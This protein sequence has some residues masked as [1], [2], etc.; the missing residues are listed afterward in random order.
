MGKSGQGTVSFYLNCVGPVYFC[1]GSLGTTLAAAVQTT[2]TS[3]TVT[4]QAN[5]DLTALPTHIIL[6]NGSQS[7][8]IRICG[9]TANVLSV[10]YDGRGQTPLAFASGVSVL[11]S[12]VTGTGTKFLTDPTAPVCPVGAPGP[13]GPSLY[14]AGTVALTANSATVTGT[15]TTFTSLMVGDYIRVPATHAGTAFI[16]VAQIAAF[17]S[18]TSLTLNRVYPTSADTA[19]GLAYNIMTG[20][21]TIVLRYPHQTDPSG[22][23]ELMWGT[24][25]GCESET[26]VYTNPIVQGNSFASGHDLGST[27]GILSAGNVYSVTDTTGWVNESSTGGINF[28]GEGMAHRALYYRSGLNSALAAA[29]VIDNYWIRSPW[30]N[31]DGNGYPRLFLGGGGIGAFISKIVDPASTV[32]WS[33]LR[34]Y[35]GLG[36][37]MINGF[38]AN[39]CNAWDDTRDSG[40]AYSWLIIAAIY[41]PDTTSTSAPGGIPWRTYWQNQLA[42]MKTNDTNCQNQTST[43]NNSFANGFYWNGNLPVLTLTNGSA[44]AT[45][46]GLPSS[47]CNGIGSGTGAVVN[48]SNV[49]TAV[50]GTFPTGTDLFLTGT[51]GDGSSVFVQS[52][53]Y[54]GTGAAG[55]LGGFWM[56]DSGTV[57]WIAG[58]FDG[59]PGDGEPQDML[60]IAMNNNDVINLQKSWACTWNSSTSITLNRPWDGASSDGTHIYHPYNGNLAGFGQQAFML[61]IKSYG[62]NLLATQT[63]PALSSYVAPYQ[64]FTANSTSWVWNI[65]MDH[66]LLGTNYGRIFQQCEPGNTAPNG[67]SSTFRAAGCTYGNDPTAVYLSR[68]QNSET[69]AA[70]AIYYQ[71]NPTSAS[72]SLGDQ[73]YGALWG[74]CPWTTGGVYCDLNSTAAN[75]AGSNLA[76]QSVHGGKWFGFFAGIGM[77]HRWPAVRQG[78]VQPRRPRAVVL[79]ARLADIPAAASVSVLVTAPSGAQTT[80]PCVGATCTVTVDDRQGTH[81]YQIQYLSSTGRVLSRS[82]PDLILYQ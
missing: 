69:G 36:L 66:Q 65:G 52:L 23:G 13:P 64:S 27:N 79:S 77:S 51:T 31:A 50:T 16:F 76:D 18:A 75:A 9:G 74:Y 3:I 43:S 60:A 33:D 81:W 34:G 37:Q 70:H 42:Q 40:Y 49:I 73:F 1:N 82:Q 30:G 7:E 41:D 61:G 78:S 11:Q 14:S 10:C 44:N 46:T 48:G 2:D 39:G 28:Y 20:S 21:R 63:L 54:S 25:G 47:M 56:G 26:S 59:Y 80:V 24:S 57:S 71:N 38:T 29:Q 53:S 35:A 12:K 32:A 22:L 15:G 67:T 55:T 19:A 5:L 6:F 17:N 62:E 68:E 4:N 45:G 58:N 72:Q 8:E